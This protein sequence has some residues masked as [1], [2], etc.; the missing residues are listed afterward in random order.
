MRGP[1]GQTTKAY[2]ALAAA[3]AGIAWSAIFV[4]WAGISGPASAFY[5]VLEEGDTHQIV[6]VLLNKGATP[7][8]FKLRELLQAGAWKSALDGKVV[9]VADGA[10]LD[11]AVAPHDVAVYVL[12]APVTEPSLKTSLDR[13]M[14]RARRH[15][16]TEAR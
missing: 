10:T 4:R 7:A 6:L 15:A 8:E 9:T 14:A 2:L 16:A 11:V 5:R 1:R 3:I 12:D 13:G